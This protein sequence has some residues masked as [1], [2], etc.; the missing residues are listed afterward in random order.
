MQIATAHLHETINMSSLLSRTSREELHWQNTFGFFLCVFGECQKR[1]MCQT[2]RLM[3]LWSLQQYSMLRY[4]DQKVEHLFSGS[5]VASH[6]QSLKLERQAEG[7]IL[8]FPGNRDWFLFNN[9]VQDLLSN[10]AAAFRKEDTAT[11]LKSIDNAGTLLRQRRQKK[12]NWQTR[13]RR[14]GW[15][16]KCEAD[17][18]ASDSDDEKRIRKAQESMP[19]RQI[20]RN[21]LRLRFLARRASG[22]APRTKNGRLWTPKFWGGKGN[23]FQWFP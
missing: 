20:K 10:T 22:D 16:W 19:S 8:K 15:L 9:R 2:L 23:Y 3:S 18:L 14:A 11:A 21:D 7:R 17:D 6:S 4:L 1:T 5:S 12:L 13:A